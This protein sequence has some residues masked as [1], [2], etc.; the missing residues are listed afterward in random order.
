[1]EEYALAHPWRRF[2]ARDIDITIYSIIWLC[3]QFFLFRWHP[4]D[5]LI[6]SILI[7]YITFLLM[8]IIEPLLLCTWGTTPGK[9]VFGLILRNQ[10]GDKLTYVEALHRTFGVFRRGYGYGIP[11]YD[12]VRNYKCYK[13]SRNNETMSWDYDCNTNYYLK[14]LKS[15]RIVAYIITIIFLIAINNVVTLQS[16]MPLHRGNISPIEYAENINDILKRPNM[17]KG[18]YMDK[19]GQWQ[20]KSDKSGIWYSNYNMPDHQLT[21]ENGIVKGVSF[22]F[23]NDVKSSTNYIPSNTTLGQKLY[24]TLAFFGAQKSTNCFTLNSSE[25]EEMLKSTDNF[26]I[27]INGIRITQEVEH[28]GY[29]IVGNEF[30]PEDGKTQKFR[31]TFSMKLIQ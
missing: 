1:M 26:D 7:S 10:N 15:L 5:N 19:S 23:E 8:I 12:L 20:E 4:E 16:Q 24:M 25:L 22:V 6:I 3:I 28:S 29:I 17:N 2:F 30:W 18:V 21:V 14:D 9:A 31:M 13:A 27:E 11:I